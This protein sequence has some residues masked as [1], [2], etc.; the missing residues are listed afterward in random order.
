MNA[1]Y[2]IIP[3]GGIGARM[4]LPYP[5]QLLPF[6]SSTILQH[7]INLFSQWPVIVPAPASFLELFRQKIGDAAMVVSGGQTRFESVRIAFE[8]IENLRDEDLVLIHDAARP[9]LD[10]SNLEDAWRLAA[11]KGAAIYADKAVDTIKLA[12]EAGMIE[13]T[14][15]R[16]RIYH[17]QTPQIFRAGLLRKAYDAFSNQEAP[18]DEARLLELAG[19]PVA[20]FPASPNNRKITRP[21]D[22]EMLGTPAIRIGHGYDVHRFDS[23]RPL[24]LGGVHIESGPGLLGHSDADVAIHALIDAMLGAA[25]LGDIGHWFPDTDPELKGVRSTDLLA[26]VWSDLKTRGYTFGNGDITIEAQIPKLAPHIQ[27][28]RACIADILETAPTRLNIKATTTERL[29]FVGREEGMAATA[30]VTLQQSI[31]ALS[32]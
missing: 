13:S 24:W 4:G 9:F 11:E 23:S 22:L 2:V 28:M 10:T 29:G 3:A 8:S 18:T 27:A 30:V 20:L 12:G 31:S 17:A 5:K 6:G 21:E 16:E 25:G 19:I 26:R 14:L 7:G 1:R 32:P 15:N